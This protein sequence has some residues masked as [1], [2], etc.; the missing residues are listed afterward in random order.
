[1]VLV[2]DVDRIPVHTLVPVG[3][4][5]ARISDALFFGRGLRDAEIL[6]TSGVEKPPTQSTLLLW[7]WLQK[8][9]ESLYCIEAAGTR[10]GFIGLYNLSRNSGEITLVIFG[11]EHRRLGYGTKTFSLFIQDLPAYYPKRIVVR[12][13]GDN[14]IA[15]SFWTKLGFRELDVRH[16]GVRTM[17]TDLAQSS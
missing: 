17:Y 2:A 8:K 5:P 3:I 1:M 15:M 4:R 13:N 12:I 10:I 14:D 16:D 9:Y 11:K 6:R 7:W